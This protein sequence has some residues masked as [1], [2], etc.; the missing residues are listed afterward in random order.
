MNPKWRTIKQH[1]GAVIFIIVPLMFAATILL[2]VFD[3]PPVVHSVK[4]LA[5]YSNCEPENVRDWLQHDYEYDKNFNAMYSNT[6]EPTGD[7]CIARKTGNCRCYAAISQDTLNE[8]PG[9]S[10]HMACMKHDETCAHALTFFTDPQGRKGFIN[11]GAQSETFSASTPWKDIEK[12][13]QGGPW[14]TP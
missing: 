11:S 7:W 8:C 10:A 2:A 1:N 12:E 14:V 5:A 9:Y 3:R 13:V 6:W 4:E